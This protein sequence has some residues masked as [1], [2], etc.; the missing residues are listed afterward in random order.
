MKKSI[1]FALT[2]TIAYM[3]AAQ[4]ARQKVNAQSPDAMPTLDQLLE[5]YVEAIGGKAAIGRITSRVSKGTFQLSGFGAKGVVELYEKA[6]N[7]SLLIVTIPGIATMQEGFNG[8]IAWEMEPGDSTLRDKTGGELAEARHEADFY[9][10]LRLKQQYPRMILKGKEKV[11]GHE[12]YVVEAPRNGNPKRWYFDAQTWLL[13]RV[14]SEVV[15]S[16]G[17][18][19]ARVYYEDYTEMDGIKIPFTIRK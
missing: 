18:S 19:T 12:V 14:D 1:T 16:E 9:K 5:N 6:P 13:I 8:A 4:G 7:K 15:S 10:S 3:S 2:L 11:A 17:K